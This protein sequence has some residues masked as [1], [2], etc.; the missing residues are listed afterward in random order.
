[1][2]VCVCAH[3]HALV[4]VRKKKSQ[5]KKTKAQLMPANYAEIREYNEIHKTLTEMSALNLS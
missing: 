2:C 4:Y 5:I 3:A 1:M